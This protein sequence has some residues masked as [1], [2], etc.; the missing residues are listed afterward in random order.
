MLRFL[1]MDELQK[2]LFDYFINCYNDNTS[3]IADNDMPGSAASIAATGM[4]LSAW[5][6]GCERSYITKAEAIAK[7]LTVLRFLHSA[8]GYTTHQGFFY[9]FLDMHSGKRVATCELSSIDTALLMAGVLSAA[10]YY[11][12]VEIKSLANVLYNRVNWRWMQGRQWSICHGWKQKSGFLRHRWDKQYSEALLLYILAM[13]SPTYPVNA[14]CYRQWTATFE[15]VNYYGIEYIYAGPLFIHQFP[16][17]W[18]DF[19]ELKG[20]DYFEN[21]RKATLV[22]QQYAIHNPR[23]FTG[24]GAD[25]W[26]LSACEGPGRAKRCFDYAARGVPFGPDDGTL[27]PLAVIASLPFAPEVVLPVLERGDLANYNTTVNWVSKRRYGL[28]YGAA[29]LALENYRSGLLW[30][31]MR[32]SPAVQQG[33]AKAGLP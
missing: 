13:G 4:G 3:L 21:S 1:Y 23:G 9:H 25:A 15:K 14:E 30:E 17:L 18:I 28:Q 20:I 5:I 32:K 22:Q 26:G 10:A 33:L 7:T 6:I 31:L 12:N 27:S 19:R 8:G 29:L 16:Q 24:Y 11:E 2:N